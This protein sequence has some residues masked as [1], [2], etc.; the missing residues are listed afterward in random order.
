MGARDHNRLTTN[1]N[2]F[3]LPANLLQSTTMRRILKNS[4]YLFSATGSAAAISMLQSILVGRLLGVAGFGLLGTII[5]FTSVVNKFVSFRMSELVIKY[6][7]S[8]SDA[9]DQRRSAAVFKAAALAEMGAS[10]LAFLLIWLLAPLAAQYLAKDPNLAALFVLYG[11]IVLANL[12]AESS[13]GV[14]Q[15]FDCYRRL[16]SFN[17]VQSLLTLGLIFWAYITHGGMVQIVIAYLAGKAIGALTLTIAAL[18]EAQRHWGR[19]WWKAPLSLLR[20]QARELTHFAVSTNISAS[21][22]LVNKDSELLWVSLF[23]SPVQ[24][25]FYKTALSIVNLVQMPVSALPQTTYPEISREITRGNWK[26][27]RNIIRQGSLLAGGFTLAATIFLA[28]FGK[29]V[30]LLLYKDPGF[31]PAYPALMIL[32]AGFMVAN[33]FYWNRIALLGLGLPAFPTKVNLILAGLKLLGILLL[34][35]RYGYLASAALFAGYY[36]ISTS[37]AAWKTY[38]VLKIRET[39]EVTLPDHGGSPSGPAVPPS[40]EVFGL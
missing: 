29:Q 15:V 4:S 17:L 7:S 36:M 28:L 38:Q 37:L 16:A 26:N 8:Y 21:L 30:I 24:A 25:G 13:T 19:G 9:G 20:P 11:L 18:V 12:I 23:R 33:T 3:R 6:V 1:R 39:T 34:V 31:L 35:P 22:N 14:L 5:M 32:L 10:V 40:G 2:P 27:V